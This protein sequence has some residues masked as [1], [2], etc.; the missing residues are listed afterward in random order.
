M[1]LLFVYVYVC[2]HVCGSTT[3]DREGVR[4]PEAGVVSG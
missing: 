3:E 1:W 4:A 2:L